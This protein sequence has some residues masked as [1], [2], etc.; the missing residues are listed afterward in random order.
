M[1][2]TATRNGNTLYIEA[3]GGA[4]TIN[5]LT[6]KNIKLVKVLLTSGA[7]AETLTLMDVTTNTVKAVLKGSA[8]NVTNEFLTDGVALV[9]PNGI[10]VTLANIDSFCTLIIEETRS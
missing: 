6:A 10:R 7:A 3:S 8:A 1:A 9:F 2:T 5:A 4:T